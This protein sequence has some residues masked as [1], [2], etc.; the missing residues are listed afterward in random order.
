MSKTTIPARADE[1]PYRFPSEEM[2]DKIVHQC[3]FP[4]IQGAAGERDPATNIHKFGC[5]FTCL[6]AIC[7]FVSG[8]LFTQQHI[9]EVYKRAQN[10]WFKDWQGNNVQALT[11]NCRMNGPDQI[12]KIALELLGDT[13]HTVIQYAVKWL[14]GGGKDWNMDRFTSERLPGKGYA[15]FV[16]VDMLTNSNPT[17]GG[18]HFVLFNAIGELIFDP[19]RNKIGRYKGPNRLSYY[20]VNTK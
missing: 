15:Y 6:L 4:I 13:K 18:H 1:A 20:K 8:K 17:Y 5:N 3:D 14:R 10:V 7:Q 2:I 19:D 11:Y 9:I 16:I 12:A